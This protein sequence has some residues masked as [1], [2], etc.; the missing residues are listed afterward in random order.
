MAFFGNVVFD[1]LATFAVDNIVSQKS[2]LLV[3]TTA[4]ACLF[5]IVVS[6]TYPNREKYL[7]ALSRVSDIVSTGVVT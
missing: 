7:D 3:Q 1:V 6:A 4:V 5:A 2:G